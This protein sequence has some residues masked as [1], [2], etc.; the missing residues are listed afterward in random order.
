M[1]TVNPYALWGHLIQTRG[2]QG[3]VVAQLE[4]PITTLN[5]VDFIFIQIGH[6]YVPYQVEEK[7]LPQPDQALFRLQGVT[8]RPTAQGII[9]KSIW[10]PQGLLNKIGTKSATQDPVV[11]Y[12]VRDVKLGEL[13]KVER[14]EAF[15]MHSCLVVSFQNKELLIPYVPA[16]IQDLDHAHQQL[17]ITLPAGFLEA[18]GYK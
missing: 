6:T 4:S 7:A 15:P 3:Q 1:N 13:G 14:I 5:P 10:L 17:T 12:S 8:D 9:G 16:W 18:M 11:G 2:L